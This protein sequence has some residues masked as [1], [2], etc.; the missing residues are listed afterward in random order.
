[1][2]KNWKIIQKKQDSER[3]IPINDAPFI[4]VFKVNKTSLKEI[5]YEKVVLLDFE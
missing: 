5:S 3:D 4:M 2:C 1:M